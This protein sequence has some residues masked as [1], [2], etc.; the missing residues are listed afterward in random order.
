MRLA[1]GRFGIN[2][3]L[4]LTT[5]SL[6]EKLICQ[7]KLCIAKFA[8]VQEAVRP[9]KGESLLKAIKHNYYTSDSK[10]WIIGLW[11]SIRSRGRQGLD[12]TQ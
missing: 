9:I 7:R 11:E 6:M 3:I 4:C 2:E 10:L 5:Y 1:C 12:P 8:W